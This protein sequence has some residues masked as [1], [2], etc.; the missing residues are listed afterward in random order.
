MKRQMSV[1]DK[2]PLHLLINV[3]NRT[4]IF[5][6]YDHWN[7]NLFL[8]DTLGYDIQSY[9]KVHYDNRC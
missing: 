2:I 9:V 4:G 7:F 6:S 5:I 3:F 8:P 1:L